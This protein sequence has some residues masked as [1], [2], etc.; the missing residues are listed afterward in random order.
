MRALS[1]I[2]F[3][4]IK[5]NKL[6]NFFNLITF[7]LAA[8]IFT[9]GIAM[10]T[11]SQEPFDKTFND[12]NTSHR[13][14]YCDNG[15][16]DIDGIYDFWSGRDEIDS[17][18]VLN[19]YALDGKI[20]IKDKSLDTY[21]VL[22]EYVKNATQDKVKVIEGREEL[23]ENQI[24]IST[25]FA[26]NND[27]KVGDEL[28][29]PAK[30]GVQDYEVT[31]IVV[32]PHYSVGTNNPTRVWVADGEIKRN[33][34][35]KTGKLFGLRYK[36]YSEKQEDELWKDFEGYLGETYQGMS[37][38]YSKLVSEYKSSYSNIGA[39]M[40]CLSVIIIIFC[41]VIMSHIIS[42]SIN[43]DYVTIGILKAQGFS[44]KLIIGS[45]ILQYLLLIWLASPIGGFLS[46]GTIKSL[47]DG[48]TKTLG[49]ISNSSMYFG[50]VVVTFI[51]FTVIVAL[52]AL[53][54]S[55]KITDIKPSQ[56]I[57]YGAP[58]EKVKECH[59]KIKSRKFASTQL[60]LSI[61][62]MLSKK[63]HS[64]I[65]MFAFVITGLILTFAYTCI[66]TYN[67]ILMD[68]SMVGWDESDLSLTN[69]YRT[70][71]TNE[72][73]E[74]YLDS[75][76]DIKICIPFQYV[77]TS[78]IQL[79][80]KNSKTVMGYVYNGNMDDVDVVNFDGKN[81]R[82]DKE[83][84]VGSAL[85]ERM[86]KKIGDTMQVNF[87]DYKRTFT[88][89]GIFETMNNSGYLY[90]IQQS[91]LEEKDRENQVYQVVLK[92]G[93]NKDDYKAHLEKEYPDVFDIQDNE[94]FINSMF[95]QLLNL[96]Y[97][98]S[99]LVSVIVVAVCFVTIYNLNNTDIS[100]SKRTFGI[101]KTFGMSFHQIRQIILYKNIIGSIVGSVVGIVVGY[102]AT[103]G[104]IRMI[105]KGLGMSHVKVTDNC[106]PLAGVVVL[107]LLVNIISTCF[108]TRKIKRI[109]PRNLIIE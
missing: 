50:S 105:M 32:D 99:I 4:S 24:W 102:F 65:I 44:T 11:M 80:K 87:G 46:F 79:D 56:A 3:A 5:R 81:P 34:T 96:I 78:T 68:P 94:D 14:V 69:S 103:C 86:D 36:H 92:N 101:Y 97:I 100:M 12:L 89:S 107:C 22:T 108:S 59:Y 76:D 13:L 37:K 33:F 41:L 43:E 95:G 64:I 2:C 61:Q 26:Y 30:G 23:G 57:R 62:D 104:V 90:R 9:V 8:L 75:E 54:A 85:A 58:A 106:L 48:V 84:T 45:Y 25:Q 29:L 98:I 10:L 74:G 60:Q 31:A 88:I 91:A 70:V 52:V 7:M 93:V 83:I 18:N 71:T 6:R 72:Q 21:I 49:K 1:K 67:G 51:V 53:K 73:L 27:I 42:Y 38:D 17:V 19:M 40:M 77:T 39:V 20:K 28:S 63:K 55:V 16:Y 47:S 109:N 82:T 15:Q 66:N 35:D